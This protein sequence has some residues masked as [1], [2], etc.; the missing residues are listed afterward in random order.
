[1]VESRPSRTAIWVSL[2]RG[3]DRF[4]RSPLVRDD[5]A[6]S[7][8]PGFSS[9]LLGMARSSPRAA[10]LVLGMLDRV[11][12]GRLRHIALRTRA[13][14][15]AIE[16]AIRDG[17][18]QIVLLGAGLDARAWRMDAL[19]ECIVFEVDHPST[20][21]YK[22]ARV[23][24]LTPSAREVRFVEVDFERQDFGQRLE[25]AGHR[26]D[27]RTV[28]VWEGV[29]M[30][31]TRAAIDRTLATAARIAPRGS[32]LIMTYHSGGRI[33]T[34]EFAVRRVGEPFV[35]TFGRAEACALLAAHGFVVVSD[36]SDPEWYVRYR[37]TTCEL[38]IERLVCSLRR[39]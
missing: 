39:A 28:F 27:E 2:W 11:S 21:S 37:S 35:S 34:L 19:R 29:T 8:V 6:D 10:R 12:R 22:R 38:T 36:E 18:R 9:R 17:A 24:G 33:R 5:V 23:D 26:P 1:M 16:H 4:D 31:L 13:I 14:D 25:E 32:T 30:Y 20:Q 15:E 7:L 3:L